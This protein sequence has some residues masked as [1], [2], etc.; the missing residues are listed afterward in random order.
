MSTL[1]TTYS[2]RIRSRPSLV[3]S[4]G[5]VLLWAGASIVLAAWYSGRI[6]DW[7][8][9]TDELLYV[10][11]ATAI[12][13]GS[14]LPTLHGE[15]VSVW[16]QLYPLLLAPFYGALAPPTAFRAGH[17]LNAVVMASAVIPAY[18]LARQVL[19]RTWSFAVAV[20]TVLVPWMVLTGF[21]MTESVAYPAF[22]WAILGLQLAIASPGWRFDLVAVAAL[23]LAVLARTQFAALVLVLPLAILGHEL[24]SALASSGTTPWWRKLVAGAWEAVRRHWLLS[25]L[26][27][28]GVVAVVA[29]AVVGSTGDL[30]GSY[31]VTVEEGSL[32]PWDTWPAA[33][34]H[35]AVVALGCGLVPLVLGGG[36]M[37]SAIARP[38]SNEERALGTLAAFTLVVLTIEAASYNVRFGGTEVIRDRYLF[39]VVPLL[40]VGTAAALSGAPRRYVAIGA[41]AVTVFVAAT[42]TQLPFTVYPGVFVDS[43]ASVLNDVLTE[44]SGALS[45]GAFVGLAALLVGAIVTLAVLLAPRVPLAVVLFVV[46]LAFQVLT[47]RS[48]VDRVLTG[49]GL[50]GRPLAGSP[51]LVLDW[52]DSVL[53]ADAEAGLIPF[54]VSSAWDTSAI[55]WWDVEFWNRS[56]TRNYVATDGNFSYTPF[57]RNA[58]RVNWSTGVVPGTADAP[59]YLV[60][61][62]GDPRLRLAG[63]QHASNVG[64]VVIAAERPY[65]ATWSSRGLETDGW[66]LRGRTATL[67][68]Y[69]R[70]RGAE[71]VEVQVPLRAPD[72]TPALYNI[73][74]SGVERAGPL[75][76]GAS[77]TEVVLVCASA[78]SPGDVTVT[79]YSNARI[80]GPPLGPEVETTRQVGV[81]VGPLAIRPTGRDCPAPQ[82]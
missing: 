80:A 4:A 64:L 35:I 8:V 37:V 13:D 42:V 45:T 1:V 25:G 31:S 20:L 41:A 63:A 33:A 44:Q 77:R 57:P 27:A 62:P 79:G 81:L 2:E 49:T 65:R 29:V 24:G 68:I 72:G 74:T 54:P 73:G 19:P 11:L 22:L 30:L 66:T 48:A 76:A 61:G 78:R 82:R 9:M 16:N 34:K 17:V 47:L 43:P 36:W 3:A 51:G 14:L 32:L 6:R 71:L 58:L 21:L 69:H 10:K 67:R 70:T 39:Y 18:L 28:A 53:P 75:F 59:A 26:Y 38:R 7:S 52:V 50:T 56:I 23:A 46:L 5:L 60:A 40:L 12:A 55:A 15:S